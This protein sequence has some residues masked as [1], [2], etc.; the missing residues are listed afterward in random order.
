MYNLLRV[1][2]IWDIYI[3]ELTQQDDYAEGPVKI[4]LV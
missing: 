4:R 2:R 1:V 3:L